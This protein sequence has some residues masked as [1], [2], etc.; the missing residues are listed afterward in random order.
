VTNV[1]WTCAFVLACI[2]FY[3]FALPALRRFNDANI[4][5]IVQEEQ[6]KTDPNAHFRHTL[7]M[8][9]EQVEPVQ[10]ISTGQYLFE[11]EIFVTRA[12]AE[13]RRAE[14][15]GTLARRFYAELP[16]ALSNR[17]G[18]RAPLS[19]RE[20]AARRWNRTVH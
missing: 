2:L 7:E 17:G 16:Q 18:G 9:E 11:T 10:E 1:Y 5:R 4:R 8:A 15:V 13:E 12:E 19:A 14:R 6:D 20:R 3:R